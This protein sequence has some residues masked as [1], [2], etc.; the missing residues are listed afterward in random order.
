ML[1]D[2]QA[3]REDFTWEIFTLM[4]D[5]MHDIRALDTKYTQFMCKV[6]RWMDALGLQYANDFDWTTSTLRQVKR[7]NRY[8][9]R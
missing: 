1:R 5:L 3:L 6:R 8:F 4:E 2:L 9:T 7:S